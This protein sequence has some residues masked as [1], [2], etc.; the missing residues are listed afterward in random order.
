MLSRNKVT[1]RSLV[2]DLSELESLLEGSSQTKIKRSSKSRRHGKKRKPRKTTSTL[3]KATKQFL[4]PVNHINRPK[5]TP[6]TKILQRLS[7]VKSAGDFTPG[8]LAKSRGPALPGLP[9]A[10]TNIFEQEGKIPEFLM[11]HGPS[12]EEITS[13]FEDAVTS[14]LISPKTNLVCEKSSTQPKS[15]PLQATL[16]SSP[17]LKKSTLLPLQSYASPPSSRKNEN[18]TRKNL[19]MAQTSTGWRIIDPAP[20]SRFKIAVAEQDVKVLSKPKSISKVVK[21]RSP[22]RQL[23]TTRL[24]R[25]NQRQTT[26]RSTYQD[27]QL[28]KCFESLEGPAHGIS[29]PAAKSIYK[30]AKRN[31]SIRK[32][33]PRRMLNALAAAES[34]RNE[35]DKSNR[36]CAVSNRISLFQRSQMISDEAA[37]NLRQKQRKK[38]KAAFRQRKHDAKVCGTLL[39][40]TYK[41]QFKTI[42]SI[43][44]SK[45]LKSLI[46]SYII[47][48]ADAG[49]KQAEGCK[50]NKKGKPDTECGNR[51]TAES[52]HDVIEKHKDKFVLCYRYITVHVRAFIVLYRLMMLYSSKH[53]NLLLNAARKSHQF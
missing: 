17:G 31:I 33:V 34:Q 16:Q 26:A 27:P 48:C 5:T 18:P 29:H 19:Y 35:L 14:P 32:K 25:L 8:L 50:R 38:E 21:K 47:D 42:T 2:V 12:L 20:Q 10:A 39:F 40:Q 53:K 37:E 15:L 36:R 49:E 51:S 23:Q 6:T 3:A 1:A 44:F 24:K 13:E 52:M 7:N 22:K 41:S 30:S 4:N 45:W 46:V 9:V 11:Q 43:A 28:R